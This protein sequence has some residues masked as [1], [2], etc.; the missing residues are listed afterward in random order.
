MAISCPGQGHRGLKP[1]P[2]N[3]GHKFPNKGDIRLG[4]ILDKT[5]VHYMTHIN[6][7]GKFRDIKYLT[8]VFRL[9]EEPR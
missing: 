4:Y 9:W 5:P 2:V 3:K 8:V 1:I 6:Y 7:M